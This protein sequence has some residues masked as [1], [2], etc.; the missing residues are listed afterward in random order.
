MQ[1]LL[2]MKILRYA[3]EAR[4]NLTVLPIRKEET[5][6]NLKNSKNDYILIVSWKILI[7]YGHW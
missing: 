4:L 1:I 6:L 5:R 2:T 7:F 3:L